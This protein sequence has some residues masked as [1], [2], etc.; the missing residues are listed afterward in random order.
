M[1]QLTYHRR[2]RRVRPTTATDAIDDLDFG[3]LAA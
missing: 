2:R 3:T 1:A